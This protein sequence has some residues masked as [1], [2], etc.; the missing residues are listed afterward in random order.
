MDA[1]K[2]STFLHQTYS[3]SQVRK[4]TQK[5]SA[6]VCLKEPA[7]V[8]GF[9]RPPFLK[10]WFK[11][12]ALRVP[13]LIASRTRSRVP[14][15]YNYVMKAEDDTFLHLPNLLTVSLPGP[16]LSS[17]FSSPEC[18]HRGYLSTSCLS[19]GGKDRDS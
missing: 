10:Q 9:L 16:Y 12:A 7:D 6:P 18:N 15:A 2:S 4:D 3:E 5:E 1:L 19:S 11:A 14:V 8:L 17:H 13:K